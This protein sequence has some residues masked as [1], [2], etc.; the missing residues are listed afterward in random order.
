MTEIEHNL[1]FPFAHCL[2]QAG[3][4]VIAQ[5]PEPFTTYHDR[6]NAFRLYQR[7]LQ[8][9]RCATTPQVLVDLEVR[10]S[11]PAAKRIDDSTRTQNG[12]VIHQCLLNG[13]RAGL[14]HTDV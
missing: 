9:I 2:R 14:R 5:K 1:Y 11:T 12:I 7:P 8:V 10:V 4:F 6:F 3:N 13:R